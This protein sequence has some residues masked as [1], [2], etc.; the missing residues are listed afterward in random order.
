MLNPKNRGYLYNPHHHVKIWFSNKPDVFMNDENQMRLITIRDKNPKDLISLVYDSSL[1][2]P[3]A[4]A[5]LHRFCSEHEI[6]PVDAQKLESSLKSVNEQKLYEYYQDEMTHL[7]QGGSLAVASD[8]IRWLS[9]VY[10][11]GTYTDFDVAV[12]TRQLP[13][14]VAV[15]TP[16]LLNIGSLKI[17]NTEIILSNNDCIAVVDPLAA[18]KQIEEIQEGFLHVLGLYTNDFI[19]KTEQ[20]FKRGGFLLRYINMYL[21]NFM[22]NRSEAI[23]I[24][25]SKSIFSSTNPMGSRQLRAYI[26]EVMTNKDK[27]LDF[28]KNSPRESNASVIQ[29]LRKNLKK[30]LS[31][32]KWMFF[33]N[34]YHEIKKMLELPDEQLITVFMKKEHSLYLRSIVVCTTGPIAIAKSLFKDYFFNAK[35][36]YEKV[37][38][39]SFNHYKLHKAFLSRNSIPLHENALSMLHF[40]G[41]GEG[42]LNDSSWL[43]EGARLQ[44]TRDRIIAEQRKILQSTLPNSLGRLKTE[45]RCYIKKMEEDPKRFWNFIGRKQRK[46]KLK[47]LYASLACF[48][49]TSSNEFDIQEF[50]KVLHQLD[51]NT[52]GMLAR[53]FYRRTL[54]LVRELE[55]YSHQAVIYGLTKNYKIKL[56]DGIESIA[57]SIDNTSS[58]NRFDPLSDAHDSVNLAFFL[59]PE[60]I[61]LVP[62]GNPTSVDK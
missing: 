47:V 16:L 24:A 2:T 45:L 49:E 3:H 1:L 11:L 27:F 10:S 18:K 29:R 21:L 58:N 35:Y 38:P 7:S 36:F 31:F 59:K 62:P 5:E 22:R 17:G 43:E 39:F 50:K 56:D 28:N 8:I 6:T 44:G 57:S 13:P 30:Q 61:D 19:D 37:Q 15:D 4:L 33:K 25:R 54:E 60:S 55:R 42:E 20:A 23:Y 26:N 41:A 52:R 48:S 40:L 51:S 12:D 9:A 53:L 34:E 14:R 46:D 32:I